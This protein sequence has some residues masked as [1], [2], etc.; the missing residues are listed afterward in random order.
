MIN[1]KRRKPATPGLAAESAHRY[2]MVFMVVDRRRLTVA[3]VRCNGMRKGST[4][5]F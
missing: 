1:V 5:F 2:L 3:L 4:G